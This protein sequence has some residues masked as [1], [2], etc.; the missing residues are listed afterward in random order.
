M[1]ELRTLRDLTEWLLLSEI[2]TIRYLTLRDLIDPPPSPGRIRAAYDAIMDTGPAAALFN[3]QTIEGKWSKD[4]NYYTPKY[5]STHWSMVLLTELHAHPGDPRLARGADYMLNVTA[6]RMH[7]DHSPENQDWACLWGNMLRYVILAGL[8]DDARVRP[9]VRLVALASQ[10]REWACRQ[11]D[12][13]P[14]AWGAVRAL[15]GLAA[16]PPE[17][18]EPFVEEAIESG[19]SF[20][21]DRAEALVTGDYP[22]PT[23]PHRHWSTFNFP[24][25]YQADILFTLRVAM[26]LNALDR[27]GAKA[28]VQWLLDQRGVNGRWRTL[29]PYRQVT[30]HVMGTIEESKR[31][32]ALHALR[33]LKAAGRPIE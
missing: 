31:W 22:T 7:N 27:P 18:R 4:Q 21:L 29:S 17:D 1:S 5:R 28:G 20:M 19:L 14:C 10:S 26:E 11:N 12:N 2:P 15:W 33:V 32:A 9:L 6:E 30:W 24:L 13:L 3:R 16:I 23:E 25:F 8:F